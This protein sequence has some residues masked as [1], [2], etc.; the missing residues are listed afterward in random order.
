M[1]DLTRARA[2]GDAKPHLALSLTHPVRKDAIDAGGGQ[3]QGHTCE[4]PQKNRVEPLHRERSRE[5]LFERFHSKHGLRRVERE[6]GASHHIC[7]GRGSEVGARYDRNAEKR[8][9]RVR[10]EQ[11][12]AGWLVETGKARVGGNADHVEARG[13]TESVAI[14]VAPERIFAPGRFQDAIGL[15]D[16]SPAGDRFLMVLESTALGRGGSS[17]VLRVVQNWSTELEVL[18]PAGAP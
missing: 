14:E 13:V 12:R 8:H 7:V 2:E 10:Q 18:A 1:H 3:G 6:R 4:Q 15:Y 5:G 9:L 17:R 16:V 11:S